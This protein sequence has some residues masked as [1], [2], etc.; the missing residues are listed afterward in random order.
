LTL[1]NTTGKARAFRYPHAIFARIDNYLSHGGRI[2][3]L[4]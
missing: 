4:S 1:G 2:P 3:G